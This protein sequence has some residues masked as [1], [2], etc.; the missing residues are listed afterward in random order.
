MKVNWDNE[1]ENLE[2]LIS[3][4]VSYERIGRQY[5]VTG[6]AIKKVAQKFGIELEKKRKVNPNEHFNKGTGQKGIC[7]NCG[8]EF[9]VYKSHGGKYCSVKCFNE[10]KHKL[11]IEAWRN[12]EKDGMSGKYGISGAIR[13]YLFEKYEGKCQIC[14]W[15]E[16]NPVTGVSPLQ[17]HHIDGDYTNNKEDNLQLLCPNCHSLTE[18]YMSLNK[19]G[20]KDREKYDKR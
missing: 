6:A 3:E 12:G 7:L 14:G 11:Y 17:I 18:T 8:K 10:H 1:K 15:G 16:I 5:N 2:R 20:R 13:K 19:K 4:G 9:T